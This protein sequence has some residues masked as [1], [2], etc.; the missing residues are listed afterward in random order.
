VQFLVDAGAD[1]NGPAVN[2]WSPLMA[3]ASKGYVEVG[4][5][6]LEAGANPNAASDS[7]K[8]TSLMLAAQGGRME[9]IELLLE[10]LAD[11]KAKTTEGKTAMMFAREND[12]VAALQMLEQGAPGSRHAKEA[13]EKAQQ[14]A[15]KEELDGVRIEL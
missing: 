9:F 8:L 12:H 14:K 1:P 13:K 6:L 15:L 2:G 10:T 5:I 7:T 4:Q 11:I 3:A